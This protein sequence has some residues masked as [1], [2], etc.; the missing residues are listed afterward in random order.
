MQADSASV[1]IPWGFAWI[2][3]VVLVS[4]LYRRRSNKAIFPR[5][6]DNAVFVEN[7][8]SGNSQR[9]ILTR[10]G[11]ARNCLLVYIEDQQ[12]HIVPHFPFNLLFLPEIY[13]L[14]AT[15]DLSRV[16]VSMP[17]TSFGR[18][19]VLV[20]INGSTPGVISNL[21]AQSG[22]APRGGGSERCRCTFLTSAMG[23]SCR[24][25]VTQEPTCQ[26]ATEAGLRT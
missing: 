11:G 6:S 25:R 10:L 16:T 13:G 22:R 15:A 18:Q 26:P 5:A 1:L 2:A 8:C 23:D 3:L 7:W 4:V 24:R 21:A 12:L 9:N 19:R 17:K 20:T 14:E